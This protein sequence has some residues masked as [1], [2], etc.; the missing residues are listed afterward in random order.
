MQMYVFTLNLVIY[1]KKN[2]LTYN[3]THQCKLIFDKDTEFIGR[4]EAFLLY[5]KVVPILH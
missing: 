1:V 5:E 3:M 4:K 2:P